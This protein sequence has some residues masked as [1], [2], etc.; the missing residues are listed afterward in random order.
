LAFFET[1]YG[2]IWPF[3]FVFGHGNPD[4]RENIGYQRKGKYRRQRKR[5]CPE[6]RL[7]IEGKSN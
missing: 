2:Q 3:K 6:L 4:M 1:P 5:F 7:F